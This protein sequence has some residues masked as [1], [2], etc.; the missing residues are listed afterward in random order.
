MDFNALLEKYPIEE[1]AEIHA[2]RL[3]HYNQLK[4]DELSNHP[5]GKFLTEY[6]HSLIEGC[7]RLL[8][9]NE[10]MEKEARDIILER[11]QNF[12]LFKSLFDNAGQKA[13]GIEEYANSKL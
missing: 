13:T 3:A 5:A 4:L 11:R 8:L 1:H 10:P 6:F 7:D 12:R 9:A 2:M